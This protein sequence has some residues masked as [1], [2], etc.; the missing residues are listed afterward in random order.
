M[1]HHS[2]QQWHLLT[3]ESMLAQWEVQM[4]SRH[5]YIFTRRIFKKDK[6]QKT[7]ATTKNFNWKNSLAGIVGSTI[8]PLSVLVQSQEKYCHQFKRVTVFVS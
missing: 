1:I 4:I 3:V 6:Q 8:P 2:D 5:L 7:M